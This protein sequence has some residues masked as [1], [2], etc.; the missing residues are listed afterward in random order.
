MSKWYMVGEK[1]SELVQF[2]SQIAVF[3]I[4]DICKAGTS[5][6]IG[7]EGWCYND[8]NKGKKHDAILK[9]QCCGSETTASV[10]VD[11]QLRFETEFN[12]RSEDDYSEVYDSNQIIFFRFLWFATEEWYQ[13]LQKIDVDNM[14]DHQFFSH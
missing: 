5:C 13:S 14:D 2:D 8:E 1:H 6:V 12:F 7:F 10:K 9:C 4:C 3:Y 11:D